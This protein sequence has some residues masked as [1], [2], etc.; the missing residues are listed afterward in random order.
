M[1]TAAQRIDDLLARWFASLE[2]HAQYLALD[3][4]SYAKVQAWPPHQRPTRWVVDLA[5]A[6]L[7]ELRRQVEERRARS[8][9][10]FAEALEL[11]G[12]L[13]TLLGSEHI[14]RFIPLALPPTE[15]TA[16]AGDTTVAQAVP[17]APA[18]TPD[19]A[20]VQA[21][22]PAP[23]PPAAPVAKPPAPD[24]A[25]DTVIGDAVRLLSWGREWPQLGSLISRLADR[26]SEQ[27]VWEILRANRALI[28][29]RARTPKS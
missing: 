12:F 9:A 20:P 22:V 5:R 21:R 24:P 13:T 2:L 28:E 23:S 10:D 8:D 29:S 1:G 11:M 4:A 27:K 3:A 6:R 15:S 18:A 25:A 14:E 26:P 17:R 19:P 16:A 7:L